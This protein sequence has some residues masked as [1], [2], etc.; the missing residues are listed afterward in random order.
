MVPDAAATEKIWHGTYS[1]FGSSRFRKSNRAGASVFAV[2]P[3]ACLM[4]GRAGRD[5]GAGG[6]R[7]RAWAN[8]QK[9]AGSSF[10]HERLI[11]T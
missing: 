1:G 11:K 6:D 9:S 10:S 3:Y 8:G 7:I 5:D 4:K 2:R